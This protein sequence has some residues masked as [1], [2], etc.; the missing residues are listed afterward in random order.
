MQVL[1]CIS[2]I[3]QLSHTILQSPSK[4]VPAEFASIPQFLH[5][6]LETLQQ[7]PGIVEDGAS[8]RVD[9]ARIMSGAENFR[10]AALIYLHRSII[11]T[12]S[13]SELM[14]DLVSRSLGIM[15]ELGVY[16]SPWPLFVT[17]CEVVGDGQRFRILDIM[18]IMQKERPLVNVNIIKNIIEALWKQTDLHPCSKGSLRVDWKSLVDLE[19]HVPCFL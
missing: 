11:L 13:N 16:T 1:E 6:Q 18:D 9:E 2:C 10:L 3:N 8:G 12:P 14:K 4:I 7:I 17:A 15:E 19:D 5:V